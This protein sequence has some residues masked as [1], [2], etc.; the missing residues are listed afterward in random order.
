MVGLAKLATQTQ[1][2][3]DALAELLH[4]RERGAAVEVR[5]AHAQQIQVGSVED[6]DGAGHGEKGPEWESAVGAAG[7]SE[8]E[9]GLRKPMS[10]C[11]HRGSPD[12][13]AFR[14]NS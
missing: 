3:R 9:W 12:G 2:A 6:V 5:L 4:L 8:F 7:R 1:F 14:V 10:P 11:F 13:S